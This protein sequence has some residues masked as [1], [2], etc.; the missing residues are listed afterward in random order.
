ML[1]FNFSYLIFLKGEWLMLGKYVLK[2]MVYGVKDEK[3]IY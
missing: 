2:L 1:N 3:G